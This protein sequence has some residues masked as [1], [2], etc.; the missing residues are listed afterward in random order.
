[1][2]NVEQQY[3]GYL[4]WRVGGF[5]WQKDKLLLLNMQGLGTTPNFWLPPGGG[6][7]FQERC[8]DALRRE[9]QEE[10]GLCVRLGRFVCVYEFIKAPLHALECFFEVEILSGTLV[11]GHDPETPHNNLLKALEWI[12]EPHFQRL[13]QDPDH[14]LHALL[15]QCSTLAEVRSLTGFY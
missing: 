3:G 4:R 14:T 9:F 7:E 11:L 10:T 5:C 1:M 6:V 2:K 12:D 8:E 13:K 15:A